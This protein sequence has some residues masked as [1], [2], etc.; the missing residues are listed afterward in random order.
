MRPSSL[1][2]KLAW[3]AGL[4]LA[5]L[6]AWALLGVRYVFLLGKEPH[7]LLV[8]VKIVGPLKTALITWAMGALGAYL[9][10]GLVTGLLL[11]GI[12][13]LRARQAS[14]PDFKGGFWLGLSGLLLAHGLLWAQVPGALTTLPLL[15]RLP[16]GP[17]VL[18]II[19]LGMLAFL[20]AAPQTETVARRWARAIGACLL[21][22]GFLLLPHD[23]FRRFMPRP[24]LKANS[25]PRV[26]ILGVDALRQ[27]MITE[28]HPDWA[29]P[30][31]ISPL[32]VVPA[33]RLA[34]N[35]L[36][37][38]DPERFT[39][40]MVIPYQSEWTEKSATVL[41][42][43][44]KQHNR[45][46]AF[47]IDDSTT[48]SFGLSQAHFAE[49]LEPSGG[50]KHFFSVGAGTCWPVYSW[51]EN[52][53]SPIETT[54]PWS[55]PQAFY[56]DVDRALER[57]DWVSAHTCQLHPPFFL[58]FRELQ[59]YRPWKWLFH[60]A[61]IYEP[62]QSQEQA[63]N[64]R[65]GRAGERGNAASQYVLRSRLVMRDL[66]PWLAHWARV[67]PNLS[68]VLTSDH[69]ED[70]LPVLDAAGNIRSYLTGVHGFD[71]TPETA[72]IPMHTF[73]V[74]KSALP[75]GTAYN[76]LDLRNDLHDWLGQ[77]GPLT[78][79]SYSSEG[80]I[81]R[82]PTFQAIH[83]MP[84]EIRDQ[85]GVEGAGL[86]AQDLLDKIYLMDIGAWWME[87]PKP[88][89][90]T[91]VMSTALAKG[92]HLICFNPTG[93]DQWARTVW[94]G[95]ERIDIQVVTKMVMEAEIEAFPGRRPGPMKAP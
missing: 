76:W 30:S 55:D 77:Q 70:H 43:K 85:G 24:A 48:L 92:D 90:G 88:S 60:T 11:R 73:G 28:F 91:K 94:R 5:W 53:L 49:V 13:I 87:N 71:L 63:E 6:A 58:R 4:W 7:P 84:K 72:R 68:G 3:V 14:V 86:R 10:V 36:L 67:F 8:G 17:L 81:L 29:P 32:C 22:M 75:N 16:M 38:A 64:D 83:A 26:L 46:T 18:L 1:R 57:H 31:G 44:A 2:S 66:D 93:P 89:D 79:K 78:L 41:L 51:T 50:W 25:T 52:L 23:L 42:D 12:S 80:L 62:Y 33:T 39:S 27:D 34:W 56:R 15:R 21:V 20:R 82:F 19:I 65:F 69:G 9:V 54:N 45:S 37:G 35:M 95:Y 47:L 74:T 61:R 59:T 40:G